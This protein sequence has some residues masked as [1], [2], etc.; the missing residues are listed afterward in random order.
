MVI[1]GEKPACTQ[2]TM[3]EG[4]LRLS[5]AHGHCVASLECV[6]NEIQKMT[7]SVGGRFLTRDR[8]D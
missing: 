1:C 2:I 5:T 6:N 3:T 4:E 8:A 7:F